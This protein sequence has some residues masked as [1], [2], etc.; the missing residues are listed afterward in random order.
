MDIDV[1]LIETGRWTQKMRQADITMQEEALARRFGVLDSVHVKST[2]S[3]RYEILGSPRPWLLAQL[4]QLPTV[5]VKVIS[6]LFESELDDYYLVLNQ[7]GKLHFIEEAEALAEFIERR[8]IS[9]AEAGRLKGKS[10]SEV[11]NLLRIL[12]IDREI[13]DEMR[14]LPAIYFGHAK[15]LAGLDPNRQHQVFEQIKR[16]KLT[17]QETEKLA[18]EIGAS[19]QNTA[20]VSSSDAPVKSADTRRLEDA[21]TT[22]L[23]TQVTIDEQSN[24]LVINY[25]N[26][27]VLQGV[28]ERLGLTEF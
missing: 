2:Q 24:D 28:L 21:L 25:S 20:A 14:G 26:L 19:G 1:D 9:Q 27:D 22:H 18:R 15:A 8:K 17:V 13:L 6:H 5:P 11:C 4:L 10:R 3:G 7:D 23:C 12:E 16:D